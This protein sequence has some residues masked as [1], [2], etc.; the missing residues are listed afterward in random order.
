MNIIMNLDDPG[1]LDWG[2]PLIIQLTPEAIARVLMDTANAV[3]TGRETCIDDDSII[4][5]MQARDDSGANTVRLVEQ[6]FA[7]EQ[8]PEVIWHDWAVEVRLGQVLI[9]GHWHVRSGAAPFEWDWLSRQA[10]MAF[11]R[12]CLLVGRRARRGVWVEEPEPRE[13]PPPRASR[14]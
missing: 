13:V 2:M 5:Q 11:E 14:H 1:E 9:T 10:E 8:E 6:E 4:N 12:A 7:D 3:H